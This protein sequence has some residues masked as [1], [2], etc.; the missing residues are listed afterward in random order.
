M[1]QMEAKDQMSLKTMQD[2]A[3]LRTCATRLGLQTDRARRAANLPRV[4]VFAAYAVLLPLPLL[5]RNYYLIRA[6]GSVGVY[7]ILA[8]GLSIVAGQA[9]L[10]DLGTPV[11]TASAPTSMRCWHRPSLGCILHSSPPQQPPPWPPRSPAWR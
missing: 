3:A 1:R 9:G 2:K 6:G 11:S 10:L 8:A 7:L 4:L 5:L